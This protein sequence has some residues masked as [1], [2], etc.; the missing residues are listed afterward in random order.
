MISAWEPPYRFVDEQLKGPYR[1]W[2]H[3][4][5]FEES[6]GGTRIIDSIQYDHWGGALVNR[7]LVRPDL[8]KIFSY[9]QEKMTELFGVKKGLTALK[10]DGKVFV[11]DNEN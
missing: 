6:R 11:F 3:E 1:K 4:H 9:R 7:L 10:D 2:I 8:E 5:R